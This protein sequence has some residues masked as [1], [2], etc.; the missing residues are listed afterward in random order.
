MDPSLPISAILNVK[1][2]TFISP[3]V[4]AE[5]T[6]LAGAR[7]L[8]FMHS[9][10][11]NWEFSYHSKVRAQKL[12]CRFNNS[13]KV[14]H[15]DEFWVMKPKGEDILFKFD[16]TWWFWRFND[17]P[18]Y[19]MKFN[20]ASRFEGFFKRGGEPTRGELVDIFNTLLKGNTSVD[21]KWVVEGCSIDDAR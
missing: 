21:R 19:R 18:I 2:E 16:H 11:P 12:K 6:K 15:I 1:V 7:T 4:G 9:L 14:R 13:K 10:D 5:P 3:S 20:D 8:S 17:S